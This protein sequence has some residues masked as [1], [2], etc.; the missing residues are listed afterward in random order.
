MTT[1]DLRR[2][3][4]VERSRTVVDGTA[5]SRLMFIF[6]AAGCTYARRPDGGCSNCGFHPLSTG[7]VS[8]AA[9]DL[10]TQFDSVFSTPG[11]FTDLVEVD[12][13]NSG[14]FFAEA[15]MPATV[16][17]HVLAALGSSSVRR[18]LVE[19]RPEF[20]HAERIQAA[21][22]RV[23]GQRLEVGIGLESADDHVREVLVNKGFGR[24]DFERAATVLA[25]HGARLLVYL[26]IKPLGLDEDQAIADAVASS[27]YVFELATR[28]RVPAHVALQPVFVAPGTAIEKAWRAGH[29]QPPSLWS[30]I[31]VLRQVHPLG[32]VTV[33]TSDEGLDPRMAPRGCEGCTPSL[34]QALQAYN[35]TRNPE[36][37]RVVDCPECQMRGR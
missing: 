11:A 24:E 4:L 19:S 21:C 32:E 23:P 9:Q 29:Y 28:L 16:R 13:F 20:V 31:E 1:E 14:S 26:L 10:I 34:Q 8:V 25:Q 2:P 22:D 6:R 30:V 36:S 33:G 27:R 37:L 7:G 5:G 3:A 18:V 17:D 15:E 12:L 35:S